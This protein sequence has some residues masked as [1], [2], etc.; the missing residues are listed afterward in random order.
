MAPFFTPVRT[1]GPHHT[2]FTHSSYRLLTVHA[3]SRDLHPCPKLSH[4]H[5]PTIAPVSR[6]VRHCVP[7]A[8]TV[9]GQGHH[10]NP[11]VFLQACSEQ[12]AERWKS[13][14]QPAECWG[15]V[16]QTDLGQ[17]MVFPF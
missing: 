2:T 11:T 5:W 7:S 12:P 17:A 6:L 14:I 8:K 3:G 16:S 9:S 1:M 13:T 4:L 10:A 15:H